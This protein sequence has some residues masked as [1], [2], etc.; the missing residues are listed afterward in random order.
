MNPARMRQRGL[1]FARAQ[2]AA[3][4]GHALVFDKRATQ[5]AGA[6]HANIRY[7]PD[8]TVHGVLYFLVDPELIRKLDPFEQA[9]IN[10]GREVFLLA[11]TADGR[12]VNV[13]AW[14]YVGNPGVLQ[15]GL[16][17][18]ADYMAHLLAGADYLPPDYLDALRNTACLPPPP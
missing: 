12:P 5:G 8:A 16:L 10:Y 15:D 7:R 17:P 9:P 2:A 3:L 1:Q 14:V 11:T 13:P 6:G 4:P 18:A